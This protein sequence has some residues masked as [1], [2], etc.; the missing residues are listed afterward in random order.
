MGLIKCP[1]DLHSMF[2][3]SGP[4]GK[5]SGGERGSVFL[6]RLGCFYL[7]H[8]S[9]PSYLYNDSLQ[10]VR[11][12]TNGSLC[13]RQPPW[14]NYFPCWQTVCKHTAVEWDGVGEAHTD[15]CAVTLMEEQ[16]KTSRKPR[17]QRMASL[18]PR[19]YESNHTESKALKCIP[20]FF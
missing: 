4:S 15:K 10:S 17:R 14:P 20:Q 18:C 2:S 13:L 19:E 6:L 8:S 5:S 7:P 3:A 12:V 11:S 1:V 9:L 16:T